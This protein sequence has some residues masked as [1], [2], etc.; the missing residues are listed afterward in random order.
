MNVSIC[1]LVRNL[2]KKDGSWRGERQRV[3]YKGCSWH[4]CW[5][6]VTKAPGFSKEG[7]CMCSS[8]CWIP[9]PNS[10][11]GTPSLCP[12]DRSHLGQSPRISH[13]QPRCQLCSARPRGLCCAL[14]VCVHRRQ[15]DVSAWSFRGY[16]CSGQAAE[17]LMGFPASPFLTA[18]ALMPV[19][20]AS[21]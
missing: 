18:R 2:S 12:R 6:Y 20:T 16:S 5:L 15:C 10:N 1:G 17:F 8:P 4:Q 9:W 21:S 14:C 3:I 13:H 19:F 11:P 7:G